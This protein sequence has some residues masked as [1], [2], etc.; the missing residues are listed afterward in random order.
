MLTFQSTSGV[1]DLTV[2][3]EVLCKQENIQRI[4]YILTTINKNEIY[5]SYR[6]KIL[7]D[8]LKHD[9]N[10]QFLFQNTID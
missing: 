2:D 6:M 1:L 8:I 7:I 9:S 5:R 10:F 4:R 3:T